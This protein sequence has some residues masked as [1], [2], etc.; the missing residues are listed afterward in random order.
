MRKNLVY[1]TEGKMRYKSIQIV[2]DPKKL[3]SV[4]NPL[5]FQ[6]LELLWHQEA[7][8]LEIS[9]T[10][11]VDEQ[12]IYYHIRNLQKAG[13]IEVVAKRE[14]KGALAKYFKTVAPSAGFELPVG[15]EPYEEVR[16]MADSSEQKNVLLRVFSPF[17]SKS[18]DFNGFIVVGSP[19]PHGPFKAH[20]RDGH[21][22]MYL[23]MAL[24]RL[25]KLPDFNFIK[26]HR[27]LCR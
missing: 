9:K 6:I 19:D 2:S 7:Y 16:G 17:I 22:A 24:G 14:I 21:Y 15:E 26:L 25:C 8:P 3:K 20:A 10:L 11:G 18:G 23:T 27:P 13:L 4:L 5:S 12:K 1:E